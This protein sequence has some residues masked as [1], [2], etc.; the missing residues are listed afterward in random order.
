MERGMSKTTFRE[1]LGKEASLALGCTKPTVFT[2]G[3]AI[4][5]RHVPGK[6]LRADVVGCGPMV[7][8]V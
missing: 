6:V 8:G 7:T 3:G 1:F 5:R 4:T 2:L